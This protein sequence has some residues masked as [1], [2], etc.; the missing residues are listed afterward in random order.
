[1]FWNKV[2]CTDK[3]IKKYTKNESKYISLYNKGFV[4]KSG[5]N[6]RYKDRDYIAYRC[7]WDVV[8]Y[9]DNNFTLTRME[10]DVVEDIDLFAQGE[11]KAM[12][13]KSYPSDD[14][15]DFL[16]DCV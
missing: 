16:T 4:V 7:C 12:R 14:L 11:S 10:R 15:L 8:L 2:K 13:L 9:F 1:M 5:M 6:D 3:L